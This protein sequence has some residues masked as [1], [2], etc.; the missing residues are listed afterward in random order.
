M[1]QAL[2]RKIGMPEHAALIAAVM[3]NF[4]EIY[5]NNMGMQR[6]RDSSDVFG[7]GSVRPSPAAS[8]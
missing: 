8:G 6:I 2:A 7:G 1:R 3:K 4:P 5:E